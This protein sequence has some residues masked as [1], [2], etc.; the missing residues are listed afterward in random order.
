MAAAD[1]RLCDLCFKK[2]YY[3]AQLDHEEVQART[4][5]QKT[6]C[7]ECAKTHDVVIIKKDN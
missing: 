2:V 1:Y 5:A 3:D 4:G 7:L 6:L